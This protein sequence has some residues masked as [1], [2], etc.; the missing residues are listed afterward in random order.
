LIPVVHIFL[1]DFDMIKE[2]YEI[3]WDIL[4]D[5][6]DLSASTGSIM[7]LLSR[8]YEQVSDSSS[9]SLRELFL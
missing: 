3:L 6:D 1:K 9:E 8:L 2:V 7:K 5:L 4:L